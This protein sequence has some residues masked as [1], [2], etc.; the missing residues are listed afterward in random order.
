MLWRHGGKPDSLDKGGFASRSG[1]GGPSG[2][3]GLSRVLLDWQLF[4]AGSPGGPAGCGEH[5]AAPNEGLLLA[6]AEQAATSTVGVT[7]FLKL[8]SRLLP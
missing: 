5:V 7:S 1:D 6:L 3:M 4:A 2:P 8:F